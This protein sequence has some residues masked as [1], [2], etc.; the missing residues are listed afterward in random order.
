VRILRLGSCVAL[1]VLYS[2]SSSGKDFQRTCSTLPFPVA[3]Q[4]RAID[5]LCPAE[6]GSNPTS[7]KGLQNQVKNNLCA[8]NDPKTLTFDNFI[9]LQNEAAS[10][11]ILFGADGFGADRVEHLPTDRSSLSSGNFQVGSETVNEGDVVQIVAFMDDP[12]PAD[13]G[14][15]ENVNCNQA[16]APENDIHINLVEQPAPPKPKT[17]DPDADQK[18]ADRKAALCKAIIAEVIPHF[19]PDTYDAR[20]LF[21]V[22][23]RRFPVKITGQLF[24]D[25]SHRPCDGDKPRD[26]S[27]RG[28]LWEIHPIYSIDVCKKKSLAQCAADDSS[29][30]QPLDQFIQQAN[31]GEAEL[32]EAAAEFE[33][34][35]ETRG[36]HEGE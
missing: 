31:I 4:A 10:R 33:M 22:A 25:A 8:S 24:F 26:S 6:G 23:K 2:T 28:T 36:E 27:V 35:E 12:H 11:D 13:L 7:P 14:S 18:K 32:A 29:A 19:R 34:D 3:T 5:S 17:G 1:S 15:G 21:A 30:W 9:T 20:F 16:D